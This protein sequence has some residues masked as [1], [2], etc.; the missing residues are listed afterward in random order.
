MGLDDEKIVKA[1]QEAQEQNHPFY[2]RQD[3]TRYKKGECV[4]AARARMMRTPQVVL[5]PRMLQG[6]TGLVCKV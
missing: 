4:Y 6:S 2:K 1:Y 5:S 3:T